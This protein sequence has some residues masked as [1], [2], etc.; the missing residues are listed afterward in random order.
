[1]LPFAFAAGLDSPVQWVFDRSRAAGLERG[2]CLVVTLSD[3]D[4]LVRV[5]A[6]AL[7]DLLLPALADLLPAAR[8]ARVER[9]LVTRARAATFRQ[10]PGSAALRP[11]TRTRL[12][13]LYLAG[14]Y[15]DTGWPDTME[16]AVRSGLRAARAALLDT[17]PTCTG[18]ST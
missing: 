10:A 15:T 18:G 12:P 1:M 4:D 7:R 11:G 2:R 14:S 8:G 3:A 9:F 5:P 17:T 13:G 16:G 6:A